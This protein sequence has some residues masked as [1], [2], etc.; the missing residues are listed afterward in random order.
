MQ[1]RPPPFWG[2]PRTV[3][4]PRASSPLFFDG[5]QH[6]L[7]VSWSSTSA[8]R[9]LRLRF[10]FLPSPRRNFFLLKPQ[11][12]IIVSLWGRHR[13]CQCYIWLAIPMW[14]QCCK[15]QFNGPQ[16]CCKKY[17]RNNRYLIQWIITNRRST[18]WV[19]AGTYDTNTTTM[20]QQRNST[21]LLQNVTLHYY[22]YYYCYFS[23]SPH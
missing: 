17:C 11:S 2:P 3:L 1:V 20:S 5:T 9:V 7:I 19:Q 10:L 18:R 13:N 23:S 4:K 22:Y 8:Y 14:I 21:Q 16:A 6:P 12:S 15:Y